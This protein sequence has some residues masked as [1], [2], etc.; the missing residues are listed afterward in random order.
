LVQ[1]LQN[2][3]R[4]YHLIEGFQQYQKQS[5]GPAPQ[6]GRVTHLSKRVRHPSPITLEKFYQFLYIGAKHAS[7][8]SLL[9]T[10]WFYRVKKFTKSKKKI[11]PK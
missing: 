3:K 1:K 8:N 2:N 4:A 9:C 6:F 11:K 5:E 7:T 10:F